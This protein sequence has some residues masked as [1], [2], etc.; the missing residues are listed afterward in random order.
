MDDELPYVQTTQ[1]N[2]RPRSNRRW[3]VGM[4]AGGVVIVLVLVIGVRAVLVRA[5]CEQNPVRLHVAAA[6][7]VAPAVQRIGQYFNDLNRDVGGHCAQVEVTED[8][9]DTVATELSGMSAIPGETP[10]DAWV[11]DSSL[12]VDAVRNSARGAAAVRPTGV[13]VAKSPLVIAVPR[14]VTGTMARWS[15]HV[16]WRTLFPQALGGPPT[17]L[18]LQ[19]QVPDPA[20]SAVGL[21]TIVEIRRLFGN[22]R[23]ARDE[24]T[25]F[26][27]NVIPT[28]SFNDPRALSAFAGL[29]EPPWNARPIT[30]TSEQAIKA[31]N[32]SNPR[33]PLTAFYPSQ[34]YD[35]DYPFAL[36]TSSALKIQAAEQFQ[37]ILRSTFAAT[38]VRGNG[39]RSASGQADQA[40]SEFGIVGSP[41]PAVAYAAPGEAS[42]ALQ[43]WK[44]LSLGSRDLVLNDISGAMTAPLVP[45]G[46][47]RLQ[48]L[49]QAAD[50]GLSLFPD[51]TEMGAWE[52]NYRLNGSLPY[53]VLVPMG[54][55]PQQLGLITRRQ[56]LQQY[57]RTITAKPGAPAAMYASVLAAFRWMTA[58]YKPSHVNALI[59]LGSGTQT[60]P[61]DMSLGALLSSLRQ[62]YDP[63]RPVEI[64]TVSAGGDADT[65]ALRQVTAITHGQSYVVER[66]SDIAHVFFDALARRICVPNC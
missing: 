65:V 27:H 5:L 46:E 30:I 44:R 10:I 6:L 38:Y 4:V 29:A 35:L 41:Q 19:I 32:Q 39:F 2:P 14:K 50:L 23:T 62:D 8:A 56:Q 63:R 54:P 47:T 22:Q 40:G 17:S 21:A 26:V 18:G 28:T 16:D 13:S 58:H 9:P 24:F 7:D 51:S 37:Q 61:H 55:L 49:E 25:N 11:P 45:G 60:A 57:T 12:W 64:I 20:H 42:T 66:P 59:V 53:R 3:I 1:P 34:E 43:A 15:R 52:Y 48:V 33:V 36:T 31:Y